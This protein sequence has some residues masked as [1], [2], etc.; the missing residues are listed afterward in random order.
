MMKMIIF[1][2]IT[3]IKTKMILLVVIF[4]TNIK[5]IPFVIISMTKTETTTQPFQGLFSISRF[6]ILMHWF[7]ISIVVNC[8]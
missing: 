5:T 3:M 7:V 8:L 6:E 4:V 2:V 1:T